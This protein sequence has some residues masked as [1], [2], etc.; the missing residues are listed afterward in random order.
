MAEVIA[1]TEYPNALLGSFEEEY[2]QIP[3]EVIITSMRENQR[4]FAVFNEKG[5][6]NHFI[7]VS[8]AVCEDYSKII[9]GNER[10]CAQDLVMQCFSIKT[11]CKVA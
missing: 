4:Y 11:I 3:S 2:L 5:L 10:V 6:S 7:V 1:I 8:N 9:H